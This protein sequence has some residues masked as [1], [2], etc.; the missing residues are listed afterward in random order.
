MMQLVYLVVGIIVGCAAVL[1]ARAKAPFSY[2][3]ASIAGI[4]GA[5][6]GDKA[7]GIRTWLVFDVNVVA[8]ILGALILVAIVHF[9]TDYIETRGRKPA[10]TH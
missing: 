3:G 9:L 5:F 10:P 7:L 4:I 1:F 2:L 6:L 8:A